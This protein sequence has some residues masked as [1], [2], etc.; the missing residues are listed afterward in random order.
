MNGDRKLTGTDIMDRPLQNA[1]PD[2]RIKLSIHPI[3]SESVFK[4]PEG[5]LDWGHNRYFFIHLLSIC[6]FLF[7]LSRSS[8]I[9]W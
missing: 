1:L 2:G 4:S 7:S 8:R 6:H 9:T 5:H 3:K